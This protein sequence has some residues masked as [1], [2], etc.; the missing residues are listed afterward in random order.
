MRCAN[1]D[2]ARATKLPW[3]EDSPEIDQR[4]EI[5]LADTLSRVRLSTSGQ[6][7]QSENPL[8]T[9]GVVDPEIGTEYFQL[10]PEVV[11]AATER[12]L[13]EGTKVP[14]SPFATAAP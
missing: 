6:R 13:E 12:G 3:A 4:R 9:D 1:S 5:R 8:H 11:G 14:Q 7:G 10:H 2:S